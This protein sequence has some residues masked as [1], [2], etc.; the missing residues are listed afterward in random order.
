MHCTKPGLI[1]TNIKQQ[2]KKLCISD[3]LSFFLGFSLFSF[4]HHYFSV[5]FIINA[6]LAFQDTYLKVRTDQVFKVK[7]ENIFI[8]FPVQNSPKE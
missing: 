8:L 6:L 4:T 1:I 2:N 5:R 3:E 7:N